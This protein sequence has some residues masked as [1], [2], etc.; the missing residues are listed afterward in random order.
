VRSKLG[1]F[2]AGTAKTVIT[3][4]V[5]YRMG[6]WGLRQARSTGVHRELFVRAL[7]LDDGET[8]LA[9][10]SL[11]VCG[12]PAETMQAI[13]RNV[14]VLTGIPAES[15]LVNS[16]HNHTAPDIILGV[17]PVWRTYAVY[18]ADLVTGAVYEATHAMRFAAVGHG[19]GKLAD[20]TVNRQYRERPV[21]DEVGVLRVDEPDGS[22]IARVVNFAAHGVCDGGQY[23]DW[24][25]DY[26]G[27]LSST[28][29]EVEEGAVA[30]HIQGAAGDIHPFD[31]WFGNRDSTHLHTHA[32]TAAF[33]E[34]IAR[35]A[36][37]VSV[38]I[39]PTSDVVLGST[40]GPLEMPRRQ[41]PWTVSAAEKLHERLSEELGNYNGDVW[42]EGT[43]TAT[44]GENHPEIYGNGRNELNLAR[45]QDTRPI[46]IH[47]QT[48]RIGE[49]LIS[50]HPGE[51][52]NELG[53][54]IKEGHS[55]ERPWVAS[56]S[57]EY[58]GYVSIRRAYGELTGVPIDDLVDMKRFRR[59]YG[60]TT[61]PFA[62]E[63]GELLVDRAI[64]I[65]RTV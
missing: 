24:S 10:V 56:Y 25:G 18:L 1:S 59:F 35:E 30:I 3:P 40:S 54:A 58:I 27:E 39:V 15:L 50:A 17:T 14:S 60:T 48:L 16:T 19:S 49:L 45:N 9:I 37:R 5:G 55:G 43:T 42:P 62:P 2:R 22:P 52:F 32:D 47:V 12:I 29:E 46:P 65:L 53:L 51:M 57:S 20:W 33:G 41:V 26:S 44:A 6:Q 34:A 13:Q 4:P 28:I 36:L 23:L 38:H 61:S 63:A 8:Q 7:V 64:E 11:E 31:W 21:D